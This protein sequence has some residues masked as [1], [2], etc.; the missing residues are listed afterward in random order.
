[1]KN[2]NTTQTRP[3]EDL[4][5]PGP[6]YTMRIDYMLH[7]DILTVIFVDFANERISIKNF[8]D[9]LIFRA[10][11]VVE[12]P[13]WDDFDYFLRSRCFPETR[14]YAKQIL[15]NLNIDCYDPLQIAEATGGKTAEDDMYM[16]FHTFPRGE[17][18]DAND[19]ADS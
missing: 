1:M 12:A 7:D 16:V 3:E 5:R 11:G 8:T 9:D 13:A 4:V 2:Q 15:R 6:D 19:P 18:Q 17:A 10:F 14:G